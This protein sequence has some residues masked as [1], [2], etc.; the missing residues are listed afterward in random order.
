MIDLILNGNLSI[1][2]PSLEESDIKS[3][4]NQLVKL[5][6]PDVC[7][8]LRASDAFAKLKYW[9]DIAINGYQYKD[10][11]GGII[12]KNN[13][14]RFTGS[15]N[16]KLLKISYDNFH[17]L[18]NKLSN[19]GI[20]DVAV[21]YIPEN[22]YWSGNELIVTLKRR[23]INL[24]NLKLEEKHCRWLLNRLMEF[25]CYSN[26]IGY[27]HNGLG[28]YSVFCT[29]DDHGIQVISFYHMM[30]VNHRMETISGLL[31]SWYPAQVRNNKLSSGNT[32]IQLSKF[33]IG[34]LLL[35]EFSIE[36]WYKLQ[37]KIDG[38][39]L[40]I[41]KSGSVNCNVSLIELK[42]YY[43]TLSDKSFHILNL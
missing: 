26:V 29:P 18:K 42:D 31:N 4:Y 8:D 13:T 21:K 39:F 15:K 30:K 37:G 11:S 17:K 43:K 22:M 38:R 20:D 5:V 7:S 36:P 16:A 19:S 27:N 35:G 32:D 40:N 3:R 33:W 1:I 28:P 25:S 23:S 34:S 12:F 6:H 41:L 24:L 10:E 2:F 9:H 14:L